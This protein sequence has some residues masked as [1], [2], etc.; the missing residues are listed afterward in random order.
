MQVMLVL[1]P[2]ILW[3]CIFHKKNQQA[4][5]DYKILVQEQIKAQH[6]EG[7]IPPF[8]Q[9]IEDF[10][11]FKRQLYLAIKDKYVRRF[12]KDELNKIK[13]LLTGST[14]DNKYPPDAGTAI[15]NRFCGH[16]TGQ[17]FQ[18]G[19]M[20]RYDHIWSQPYA[21]GDGF[22][23]QKVIIR[24]FSKRHQ[25][26][27]NN[28]IAINSYNPKNRLFLGGVDVKRPERK[29]AYAPHWGFLIDSSTLAW[30]ACF[31]N[32]LENP[33]YSFF[34][35]KITSIDQVNYYKVRGVGF[36]WDRGSKRIVNINWREGHYVQ[37]EPIASPSFI[38]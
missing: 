15:L 29:G 12:H 35:E 26:Y 11:E 19:E 30:I 25:R 8:R 17:W 3:G 9:V 27:I 16:W 1:F 14:P 10:Q 33:S 5:S 28:K 34:Y 37:L 20:S 24:K 18:N 32:G 23:A 38:R 7:L 21:I 6:H 2:A 31:G 36:K 4:D 22:V 13:K